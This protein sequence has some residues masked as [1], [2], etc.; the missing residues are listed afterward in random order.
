MVA[1]IL[2]RGSWDIAVGFA[3]SHRTH[4]GQGNLVVFDFETALPVLVVPVTKARRLLG[5]EK[6]PATHGYYGTSKGME[7]FCLVIAVELLRKHK[8]LSIA[9]GLVADADG[10]SDK[11]LRLYDD[12]KH[13]V[14]YLDPGHLAKN[15]A[16]HCQMYLGRSV[17]SRD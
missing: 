4:A 17:G 9:R 2:E 14:R 6:F 8:L 7:G 12:T 5:A 16:S 15:I 1:R 10:Q 11:V 3:W 13:I